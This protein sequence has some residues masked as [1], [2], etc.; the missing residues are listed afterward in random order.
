RLPSLAGTGTPF[1]FGGVWNSVAGENAANGLSHRRG[2]IFYGRSPGPP[3]ASHA[4]HGRKDR[5]GVGSGE[6]I[7]A[8]L[9]RFRALC[10]V[11]NGHVGNAQNAGFLLYRT[12]IGDRAEGLF[13]QPDE[14]GK[15]QRLDKPQPRAVEVHAELCYPGARSRMQ[16]GNHGKTVFRVQKLESR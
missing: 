16:R 1:S 12:A 6:N 3:P 4:A 14:V 8:A 9:E 11:P 2:Q 7:G 5:V 15:T 10:D 13:L